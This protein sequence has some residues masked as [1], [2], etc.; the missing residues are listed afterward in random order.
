MEKSLS[1]VTDGLENSRHFDWNY[2]SFSKGHAA[3]PGS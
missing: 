3:K 1:E 2:C